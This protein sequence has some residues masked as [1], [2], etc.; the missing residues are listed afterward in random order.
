MMRKVADTEP[1]VAAPVFRSFLALQMQALTLLTTA[2]IRTDQAPQVKRLID[3]LR[4]SVKRLTDFCD[5]LLSGDSGWPG[6][7]GQIKEMVTAKASRIGT[8]YSQMR[9]TVEIAKSGNDSAPAVDVPGFP[10]SDDWLF[11]WCDYVGIVVV[12]RPWGPDGTFMGQPISAGQGALLFHQRNFPEQPV[13]FL[14]VYG[15][16]RTAWHPARYALPGEFGFV[17]DLASNF[18]PHLP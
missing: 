1:Q 16:P 13:S 4:Q 12:F 3:G 11:K 7:E 6:I 17:R 14:M 8:P 5:G 18:P 10:L 2:W 9:W 15:D